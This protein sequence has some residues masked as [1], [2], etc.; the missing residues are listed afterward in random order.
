MT[1]GDGNGLFLFI[2]RGCGL[3]DSFGVFLTSFFLVIGVSPGF[4][5]LLASILALASSRTLT[6]LLNCSVSLSILAINVSFSFD[7]V[8]HLIPL[9]GGKQNLILALSLPPLVFVSAFGYC[10]TALCSGLYLNQ[11]FELECVF[12]SSVRIRPRE[13]PHTILPS[14]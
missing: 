13:V 9:G 14:P 7:M 4:G 2:S 5:F 6:A 11:P 8:T 12:I 3:G 1:G 10:L